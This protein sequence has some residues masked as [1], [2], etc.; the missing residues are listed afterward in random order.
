MDS[1]KYSKYRIGEPSSDS[2]LY[3]DSKNTGSTRTLFNIFS[4]FKH[5]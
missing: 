4:F 2:F 3:Y 5:W 1:G